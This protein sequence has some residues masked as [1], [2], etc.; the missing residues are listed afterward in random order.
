MV[1]TGRDGPESYVDAVGRAIRQ[2]SWMKIK[3][4]VNVSASE[5]LK[6]V[7]QP[8]PLQL[9]NQ[10]SDRRLGY[11]SRKSNNQEKTNGSGRKPKS[12]GKRKNG[13]RNQGRLEWFEGRK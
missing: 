1:D 5:G 8:S 10:R 11:Q 2:E 9:Y 12:N 7:I 13:P 3:N 6:E 4:N